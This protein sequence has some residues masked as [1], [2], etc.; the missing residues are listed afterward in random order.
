MILDTPKVG[1]YSR[2]RSRLGEDWTRSAA[3][4][5]GAGTS[6]RY[7]RARGCS[8][9]GRARASQARGRGFEARRPLDA[10]PGHSHRRMRRVRFDFRKGSS[11]RDWSLCP[12]G[13]AWPE[14]RCDAPPAGERQMGRPNRVVRFAPSGALARPFAAGDPDLSGSRPNKAPVTRRGSTAPAPGRNV[15]DARARRGGMGRR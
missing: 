11:P 10:R 13:G 1:F 12:V 6:R 4:P 15:D 8:S 5:A 3:R 7:R 9:V 14:R 2:F